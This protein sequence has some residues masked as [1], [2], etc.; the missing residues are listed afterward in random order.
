MVL[1]WQKL[2]VKTNVWLEKKSLCIARD[3]TVFSNRQTVIII[4]G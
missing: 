4:M 3:P 1:I 2:M